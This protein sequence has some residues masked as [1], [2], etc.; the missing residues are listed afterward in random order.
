MYKFNKPNDIK[1][2]PSDDNKSI[3][4]N[5]RFTE[6]E[7][8]DLSLEIARETLKN[9]NDVIDRKYPINKIINSNLDKLS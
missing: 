7:C 4:Y 1:P 3:E 6:S 9:I 8:Y 2:K 5:N